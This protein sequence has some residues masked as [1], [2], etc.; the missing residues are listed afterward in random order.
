MFKRHASGKQV[1]WVLS[2]NT[3]TIPIFSRKEPPTELWWKMAVRQWDYRV[4]VSFQF[5]V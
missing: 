2:R 3:H 4:G 5:K 1:L